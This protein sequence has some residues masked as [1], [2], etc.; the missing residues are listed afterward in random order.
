MTRPRKLPLRPV[1]SLD[2]DA[3]EASE[4]ELAA[5]R[6]FAEVFPDLAAAMRK[7]LGGRPKADTVKLPVS[8]RL[9]ADVVDHF[10]QSGAGWQSRMNAALR[11]AAGLD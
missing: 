3:P 6:P 5:A 10:R 9:D 4:T 1:P 7:N 2:P 8:L 11:K